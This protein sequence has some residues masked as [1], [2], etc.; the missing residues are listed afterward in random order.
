MSFFKNKNWEFYGLLFLAFFPIFP[1][2]LV[3]VAIAFFLLLSVFQRVLIKP[4][5]SK[6]IFNT[7]F[8]IIQILF[9]VLLLCISGFKDSFSPTLKYLEPSISLLLFPVFW[10]VTKSKIT[11]EERK[12]VLKTFVLSSFLLGIYIVL[13]SIYDSILNNSDFTILYEEVP[14]LSIHPLYVGLYFF[15]SIVLIY[16]EGLFINKPLKYSLL[17]FFTLLI[18]AMASRAVLLVLLL[19]FAIEFFRT[20]ITLK[21]KLAIVFLGLVI[22]FSAFYVIKPLQKKVIEISSSEYYQLPNKDWPTSAQIRIGLNHCALPI[23]KKNWITGAGIIS[24]ENQLNKCYSKFNNIEKI[25]YN[26]HNYYSFLLG[27]GGILCLLSFLL[28]LFCH[29]KAAFNNSNKTHLYF[30]VLISLSLLTENILSRVY[31]VVFMLFFMTIFVKSSS[32]SS[33]K[34]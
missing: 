21:S 14:I 2:F 5:S 20:R 32:S 19:F 28:L 15:M 7:Q 31:G 8:F 1:F 26:S 25:R 13:F 18:I 4:D 30:L 3:S 29:F 12:S 22:S 33:Q 6:S 17:F 11:K 27:S 23:V 34:G 24:F 10:Y 16:L 9:F